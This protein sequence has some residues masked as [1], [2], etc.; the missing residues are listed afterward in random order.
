MY[1]TITI[2]ILTLH[3]ALPILLAAASGNVAIVTR[4]LDKGADPNAKESAH[5]QTALM[6]DAARDRAEVVT[7][8]LDRKRTRLNSS[9]LVIT[10]AVYSLT[11][12]ILCSSPFTCC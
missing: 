12:Y 11:E 2:T 7:L 1:E 9:H 3:V 10:Y 8:L 5:G 4:L 6:F